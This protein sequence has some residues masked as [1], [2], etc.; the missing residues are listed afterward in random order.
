M[1]TSNNEKK[2]TNIDYDFEISK[3][4]SIRANVNNETKYLTNIRN[5]NKITN[6]SE[7]LSILFIRGEFNQPIILPDRLFMFKI[8]GEFNQ[9]II[10]P[11]N[12][13]YF[14]IS[15]NFNQPIILPDSLQYLKINGEELYLK[16]FIP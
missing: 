12:I 10:L 7:P 16:E 2:T 4:Q 6:Q 5:I 8:G 15:R 14:S 9:P 11:N 13:I 3:D 1:L